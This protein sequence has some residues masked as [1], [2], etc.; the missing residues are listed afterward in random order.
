MLMCFASTKEQP[1]LIPFDT[2]LHV[3]QDVGLGGKSTEYLTSD[4]TRSSGSETTNYPR[5]WWDKNLQPH[6]L[7]ESSAY[8]AHITYEGLTGKRSPRYTSMDLAIDAAKSRSASGGGE[9]G[10]LYE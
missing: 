5:I 3:P 7:D 4:Y 1:N 10:S 6:V 8:D 2:N 9:S